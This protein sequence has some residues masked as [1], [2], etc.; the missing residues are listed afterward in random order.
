MNDALNTP[1]T[2]SSFALVCAM[3]TAFG[4]PQG[5]ACDFLPMPDMS[6]ETET[7]FNALPWNRLGRQM[8]NIEDEFH[9]L[10]GWPETGEKGAFQRRDLD[11][12]RDALCD[13]MVF[14]LG[15]YHFLGID[16]DA[17]MRTVVNAVMTRFIKDD[18]DKL[19]TIVKHA[20]KGV[21]D[22]YF[23]GEYP[24]MIMKSASD[25]PDAPRGKFLKSAS[26]VEPVFAEITFPRDEDIVA[27]AEAAKTPGAFD[28]Q[29]V[30]TASPG[31]CN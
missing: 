24:T 7:H 20:V 31:D 26:Y 4:N 23:E 3:N 27:V 5:D 14:A 17:D 16:A 29:P 21:T 28:P 9:E 25:Q 13:I 11:G 12:V 15:A 19:A 10:M 8:V 22:V 2:A 1:D 6:S 18:A 30:F